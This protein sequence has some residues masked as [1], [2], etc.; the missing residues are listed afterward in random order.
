MYEDDNCIIDLDTGT[1]LSLVSNIVHGHSQCG[2][3]KFSS[4][5]KCIFPTAHHYKRDIR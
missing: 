3:E 2:S 1:L 4:G 5:P